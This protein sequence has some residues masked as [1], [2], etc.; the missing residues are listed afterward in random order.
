MIADIN[1][2]ST[3]FVVFPSVGMT[4]AAMFGTIWSIIQINESRTFREW[5]AR[6]LIHR[7]AEHLAKL[8]AEKL[9]VLAKIDAIEKSLE[10][11]VAAKDK[12][13]TAA[14]EAARLVEQNSVVAKANAD[15]AVGKTPEPPTNG[16]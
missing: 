7:H 8:E 9:L 4:L 5:R 6:R 12:I 16:A 3:L 1:P 2:Q 13:E 11:W 15:L 10:T 14:A